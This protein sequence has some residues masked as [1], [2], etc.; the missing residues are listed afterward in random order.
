MEVCQKMS[1][2]KPFLLQI[3]VSEIKFTI[4]KQPVGLSID[5]FESVW[6]IVDEDQSGAIGYEEFLTA[7]IGEMAEE[8]AGLV[9]K[10]WKKLDPKGEGKCSVFD[11]EKTLR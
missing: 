5:E 2:N 6:R 1:Y 10:A 4:A 9:Q 11:A 7:F 8:R 3:S